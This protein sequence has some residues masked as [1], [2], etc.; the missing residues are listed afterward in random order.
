MR[1]ETQSYRARPLSVLDESY[2]IVKIK[3]DEDASRNVTN[4]SN[5]L[6]LAV[7]EHDHVIHLQA[8]VEVSV[9]IES[10]DGQA[11]LFRENF[12]RLLILALFRSLLRLGR[13]LSPGLCLQVN[14]CRRDKR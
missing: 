9:I 10:H 6:L 14:S 3:H 13:R 1:D 4:A 7:F 5:L 12:E 11:H 2:L 8:W